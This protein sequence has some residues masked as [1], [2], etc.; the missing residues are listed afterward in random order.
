MAAG[1]ARG[2]PAPGMMHTAAP[3]QYV[4]RNYTVNPAHSLVNT[5][6]K[7]VLP[8]KK[9]VEAGT[10]AESNSNAKPTD[11]VRITIFYYLFNSI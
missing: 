6:F 3:T 4:S 5:N 10:S 7:V 2:S 9:N 8:P 1:L 11:K